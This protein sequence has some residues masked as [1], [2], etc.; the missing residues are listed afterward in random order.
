MSTAEQVVRRYFGSLA[1]LPSW[2]ATAEYGSWLSLSFGKPHVVVREANPRSRAKSFRRRRTFVQ[3]DYFLWIEMGD[4]EYFERRKRLSS[5]RQR[6][7]HLRRT[8]AMLEA[9]K[10]T[11]FELKPTTRES[12]FTFDQG[13]L[14]RVWP[15]RDAKPNEPLWHL[16][17]K[18]N[19]LS[20]LADGTLEHGPGSSPNPKRVQATA[21]KYA[22]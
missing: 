5:S 16:Y 19:C 20:F 1:D 4:W 9:Q 10:L 15:A 11:R 21:V 13:G 8:A 7:T 18:Q 12:V 22:A 3:G 14:L 6:R 2:N 17:V